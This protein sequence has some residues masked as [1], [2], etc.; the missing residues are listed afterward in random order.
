MKRHRALS[1]IEVLAAMTL[2]AGTMVSLVLAQGRSLQ[3]LAAT[4]RQH[5]ADALARELVLHWT[6]E[7]PPSDSCEGSFGEQPGWR[8]VRRAQ[9]SS[10][11]DKLLE[12][13]VTIFAMDSRGE[14][15][16]ASSLVWLEPRRE[17][18]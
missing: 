6:M 15:V 10:W 1:L 12:M 13:T 16:V 5:T 9:P 2:L 14:E 3:Q 17:K 7:P 11:D 4:R 8:Y 18:P